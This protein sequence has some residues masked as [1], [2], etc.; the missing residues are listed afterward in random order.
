MGRGPA[1]SEVTGRALTDGVPGLCSPVMLCWSESRGRTSQ[2]LMSGDKAEGQ[3]VSCQVSGLCAGGVRTFRI[4]RTTKGPAALGSPFLV[5][6]P[7]S[8]PESS[9]HS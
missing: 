8:L 6:V 4:P 2:V 7:V 3:F 1:V 9:T 5:S